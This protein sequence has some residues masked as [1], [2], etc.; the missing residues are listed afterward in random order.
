[1]GAGAPAPGPCGTALVMSAPAPSNKS[2]CI[3]RLA[4]LA[5]L[6]A[7]LG[8]TAAANVTGP[9]PAA[10]EKWSTC[11]GDAM[12]PTASPPPGGS[13]TAAA[14]EAPPERCTNGRRAATVATSSTWLLDP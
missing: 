1:M 10:N 2:T 11:P 5:P 13:A 8:V 7:Q 12:V 3:R 4:R 9:A 14:N 6:A